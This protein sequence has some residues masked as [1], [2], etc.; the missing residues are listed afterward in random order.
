M[1]RSRMNGHQSSSNTDS[2]DGC[3]PVVGKDGEVNATMT[4]LTTVRRTTK[5][6]MDA[7]HGDIIEGDDNDD[8]QR[9][10]GEFVNAA[11]PAASVITRKRSILINSNS[12]HQQLAQ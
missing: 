8:E 10:S 6:D 9:E 11:A 7:E 3:K 5:V 1:Y 2:G 12:T 4:E